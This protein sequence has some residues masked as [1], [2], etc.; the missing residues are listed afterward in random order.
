[1]SLPSRPPVTSSERATRSDDATSRRVA[2]NAGSRTCSSPTSASAAVREHE[3]L[4]A[5]LS[6]VDNAAATMPLSDRSVRYG[7]VNVAVG[8][9]AH[10]GW[11]MAVVVGLVD[12]HLR[13]YD[14]RRVELISPDLPRQA[15]H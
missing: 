6:H 4:P 14:R 12:G 2:P 15:Y 1:M 7:S 9:A 8:F 10:S 11:A 13:V 5:P 3:G